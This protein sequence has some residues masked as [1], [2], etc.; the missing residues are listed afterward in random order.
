MEI[1]RSNIK[2]ILT[3]SYISGNENPGKTSYILGSR[4]FYISK[5]TSKA[6][7]T[8]NY[9]ISPKRVMNKFF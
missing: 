7:K 3:C 5:R 4:A 1:S 9:Y 8:K 2:K 6:P